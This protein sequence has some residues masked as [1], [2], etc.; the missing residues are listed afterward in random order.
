[1]CCCSDFLVLIEAFAVH[2]PV[3]FER[4]KNPEIIS[5]SKEKKTATTI[6]ISK[7]VALR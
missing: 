7:F 3:I 5:V 4:T 1:M 2:H 6:N